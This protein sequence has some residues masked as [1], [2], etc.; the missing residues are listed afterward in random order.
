MT[1]QPPPPETNYEHFFDLRSIT[2]RKISSR[3]RSLSAAFGDTHMG[4]EAGETKVGRHL[5]LIYLVD[6]HSMLKSATI[7]TIK[8]PCEPDFF[9]FQ[10]HQVLISLG[11]SKDKQQ[12]LP[13]WPYLSTLIGSFP[14]PQIMDISPA[15]NSKHTRICFGRPHW[16]VYWR[17]RYS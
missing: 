10:R 16:F 17:A 7:T 11:C 1:N 14:P 9:S 6:L 5:I 2:H 15:Q 12:N 13:I 8:Q 4:D 3:V